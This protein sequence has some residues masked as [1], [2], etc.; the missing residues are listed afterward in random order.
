MKKQVVWRTE[1]SN[2]QEVTIAKKR[3]VWFPYTD[4]GHALSK[5]GAF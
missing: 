2:K 3:G 4:L 1:L 5:N